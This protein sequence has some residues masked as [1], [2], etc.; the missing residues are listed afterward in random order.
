MRF[1]LQHIFRDRFR[2]VGRG[3]WLKTFGSHSVVAAADRLK[4][5]VSCS[6]SATGIGATRLIALGSVLNQLHIARSAMSNFAS[7]IAAKG[8]PTKLDYALNNMK[9]TAE[10]CTT[11]KASD[12]KL[13]ALT[14]HIINMNTVL[15]EYV[16]VIKYLVGEVDRL[17]L[18][19]AK[20]GI[21]PDGESW[22]SQANNDAAH[23]PNPTSDLAGALAVVKA[24]A[25]S[26]QQVTQYDSLVQ[27]EAPSHIKDLSGC[28]NLMELY[29]NLSEFLTSSEFLCEDF[30]GRDFSFFNMVSRN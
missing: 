2:N 26:L 23:V 1:V 8:L 9:L 25:T 11:A 12:D 4:S 18:H 13:A 19:L 24:R 14:N 5:A 21:I 10:Q 20:N 16:Q 30:D 29:D 22:T 7:Q 17:H 6:L 3:H 15:F 28:T 27:S